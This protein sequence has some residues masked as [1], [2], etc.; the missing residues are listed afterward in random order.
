[1]M[2]R[3]KR[4]VPILAGSPPPLLPADPTKAT[5]AA[6]RFASYI[7]ILLCPWVAHENLEGDIPRVEV[8]GDKL[9]YRDF[10]E[11][12]FEWETG[13]PQR[14]GG[15]M[16]PSQDG[17]GEAELTELLKEMG[18]SRAKFATNIAR[19]LRVNTERKNTFTGYRYSQSKQWD[20]GDHQPTRPH[21]R[22]W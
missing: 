3:S 9:R 13:I 11:K 2:L 7:L 22:T 14:T 15:Y 12:M 18:H 16:C 20:D 1:M 5:A 8:N 21:M 10:C 6:D 4:K 17:E 19:G